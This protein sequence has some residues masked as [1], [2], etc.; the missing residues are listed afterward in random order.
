MKLYKTQQEAIDNAPKDH[1]FFVQNF[2][3]KNCYDITDNECAGWNT[4][5]RRCDCGNRR[6]E[7]ETEQDGHGMWYAYASAY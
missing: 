1:D 3:G 2:D 4:E 5:D 7:W 6:V